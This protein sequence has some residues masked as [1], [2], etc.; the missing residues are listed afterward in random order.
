VPPALVISSC[1]R[2][3]HSAALPADCVTP[4]HACYF[5]LD[6]VHWHTATASSSLRDE[7]RLHYNDYIQQR[8]FYT[9]TY[10]GSDKMVSYR[11]QIARQS[12]FAVDP[13]NI[14]SHLT[15]QPCKIWLSF[16]I[17]CVR[18]R[19][20]P[21]N[22]GTLGPRSIMIGACMGAWPPRNT[23]L[24]HS[25]HAKFGRSRSNRLGVGKGSQNF[26]DAGPRSLGMGVRMIH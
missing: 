3:Y 25:Y 13:V 11:K 6:N 15:S 22:W 5:R 18:T 9:C 7:T 14:S 21:Q 2:P 23:L 24:L 20:I 4:L 10:T 1:K 16:L 17:L 12:A 8:H 19:E 26:W